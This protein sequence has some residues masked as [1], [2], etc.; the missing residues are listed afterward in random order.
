MGKHWRNKGNK[1]NKGRLGVRRDQRQGWDEIVKENE[2]WERYY[3][4][5]QVVSSDA[6]FARMKKAF[7]DPLPVTFRITGSR[8]HVQ[9]IANFFTKKIVPQLEKAEQDALANP[10]ADTENSEVPHKPPSALS[11]YPSNLAFQID[12]PKRV[13]KKDPVYGPVQGFL[14]AE[15]EVGNLS[16]QEAVS[17]IPPLFLGVKPTHYVLDMCAAPGSKTA[18]LIEA[19]HATEHGE[20][21][22]GFVMA[23]DSDYR[24]S[25]MLVHQIKRLNSP[26]YVIV[27]HDAQMFPKVR[28]E[29]DGSYIK[30]DRILCDVPCSG[31]GTFRKN[32]PIWKEWTVGNGLGL[33]RLQLNILLRG[34]Q[35]LKTGGRLVYSTCSLNPIE[36]ESV[37]ASALKKFAGKI[38]IVDCSSEFT[39]LIRHS[40]LKTWKVFNKKFEL[41]EPG[42]KEVPETVFPPKGEEVEDLHLE[43][44]MRVYPQDQNTG[45]FFITVLERIPEND[46]KREREDEGS[47]EVSNK[48]PKTDGEVADDIPVASPVVSS[49]PVKR[50]R[51]PL[52]AIEEPFSYVD[53]GNEQLKKCFQFYEIDDKFPK[54]CTMV[55]NATGE[56]MRSI[57]FTAPVI[58][59]II[60]CNEDKLKLIYSG[61]KLFVSQKNYECPW[62]IQNDSV[63]VVKNHMPTTRQLT[64]N[65]GIFKILLEE[66]Y[67]SFQLLKESKVD[68][69]FVEAIENSPEGSC[70]L[71]IK[72]EGGDEQLLLPMWK[73]RVHL[74]LM[75]DKHEKAELLYRFFGVDKNALEKAKKAEVKA[76]AER[77]VNAKA[78]AETEAEAEAD[79]TTV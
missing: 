61:V 13:I 40:G 9:D 39:G 2:E 69:S 47:D 58:K 24:R 62:R 38:R 25:Y 15:N 22:T 42:S 75:V 78:E 72:R 70:F 35:L 76:E 49:A 32:L 48:K 60:Q 74:N 45:G 46:N 50:Q 65:M 30:F 44:C 17:M 19:I 67:P 36:D 3:K 34:I 11:W 43:R 54:D 55:R 64:S 12:L 66:N 5:Q 63:A 77:E 1:S 20:L 10:D 7:Q 16:R 31:D 21:P 52:D 6:E 51:L 27:N 18:Q 14:V 59:K 79:E 28:L 8:D 37:V 4:E 68:P 73:G 33:H 41:Q 29:K 23:N 57:Y 71:N 56:P 26:S 53:I